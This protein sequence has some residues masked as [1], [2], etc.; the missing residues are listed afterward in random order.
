[1]LSRI[2]VANRGEIALRDHSSL[3]RAGDRDG[4]RL[5]GGG[6]QRVLSA[7]GRRGHL[8][9]AGRL[10]SELPQHPP[11]H[12]CGGDHQRRCDPPRLRVP[13]REYRASRR[14][15]G[16]AASASSAPASRPCGC[17]ATRSRPAR[18]PSKAKV[19]IVPGSEGVLTNE[20]EAMKLANQIGYPVIIKAVSGGGGRGM[21]VVH[22]DISLRAAFN[23]AK[24]EAEAAFGDGSVYLEKFIVE[25][26]HVEVQ[27]LADHEGNALHFYERDCSIQ[28][29][30]QKMIEESPCPVLRRARPPASVR[31]GPA[32]H[33]RG[34]VRQRRHRR[35]PP[36]QGQQVLLHR[37]QH[38]HPGRAPG[39]RDGHRPR[40]H[41][42]AD[43]DRQRRAAQPAPEGHHAPGRR[44]R[45]PDQRGGP[46]EQL[47][48]L[49]RHDH[50]IPR[51]RRSRRPRGHP[52][53]PGLDGRP[54]LRLA[55]RQADRPPEDRVPRRSPRCAG[56]S[57][58][59]PSAR[60]RPRSPP[61]WQILS[62]NLFVKGKIDT[63]FVERNF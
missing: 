43:P 44:D 9:R 17:W 50:R 41:Q 3:P 29:R 54:P 40:P 38:P 49:P 47:L 10:R 30:H 62:H 46:G 63:G 20:T 48:P 13:R 28:R 56:P 42:V 6:S 32:R 2:L 18:S 36:R 45:M 11:D 53:P 60:S 26:R 58:N 51:P 34:Q 61:A 31:C 14:S 59:S 27:V 4:R 23:A 8:H 7:S 12:Q 5:L 15:A 16:T 37:G 39:H 57:T 22:N 24:S 35:V 52:R 25:P 21:R 55:H 33:Q 19:P 1:M